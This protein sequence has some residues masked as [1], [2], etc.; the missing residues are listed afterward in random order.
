MHT[1]IKWMNEYIHEYIYTCVYECIYIMYTWQHII[2]EKK[3]TARLQLIRQLQKKK[4]TNIILVKY[5][6]YQINHENYEVL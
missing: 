5:F 6:N 2:F 1:Y 4:K 3:K